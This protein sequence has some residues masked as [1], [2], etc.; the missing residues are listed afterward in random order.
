MFFFIG[1]YLYWVN[2]G[3]RVVQL[4]ITIFRLAMGGIFTIELYA[5]HK[6]F[7][8]HNPD[9]YR[10]VKRRRN[11]AYCQ[12]AV[13]GW[14]YLCHDCSVFFRVSFGKFSILLFVF[15]FSGFFDHYFIIY[16]ITILSFLSL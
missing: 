15:N 14:R 13:T 16:H 2:S 5:E 10:D 12:C 3:C 6:T 4:P 7:G 9:S 8:Y 11:P 1:F